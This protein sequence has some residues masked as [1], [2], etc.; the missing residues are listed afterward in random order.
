M[1]DVVRHIESNPPVN[2]S[3]GGPVKK[4][5]FNGSLTQIYRPSPNSGAGL[6]GTR[7]SKSA[8][9]QGNQNG[10][11]CA[12]RNILTKELSPNDRDEDAQDATKS[13]SRKK[14]DNLVMPSAVLHC[15]P[16]HNSAILVPTI[17]KSVP[18]LNPTS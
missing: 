11:D 14:N 16:S 8:R 10:P 9:N 5:P 2:C 6:P 17:L 7:G 1:C 18:E 4:E 13:G 15:S 3:E 12:A